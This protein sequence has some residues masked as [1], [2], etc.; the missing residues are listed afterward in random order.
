[1]A[2]NRLIRS[3]TL[4][5]SADL[6]SNQHRIMTIDDAGRLVA[7]VDGATAYVGVLL[8]KPNAIDRAG[9]V[10]INGSVVK[11]EAGAAVAERD[12]IIA[13]A[14]GRGSPTTTEDDEIIGY[15]LTP[16]AASAGLGEVVGTA[17]APLRAQA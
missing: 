16:A 1:M 9:E 17:P 8:N 3:I 14:G 5:A 10:A 11:L 6:S 7:A 4:P 12:A 15:A 2:L 13:V